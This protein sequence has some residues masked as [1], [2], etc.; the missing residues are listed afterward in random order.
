[1]LCNH[2]GAKESC[3]AYRNDGQCHCLSM[4]CRDKNKQ[5][6]FYKSKQ[7]REQELREEA[8]ERNVS[9][10]DYILSLK[11]KLELHKNF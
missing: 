5:C 6:K 7:K 4:P 11:A 10:E 3:F 2:N 9:Y 1:M 8:K